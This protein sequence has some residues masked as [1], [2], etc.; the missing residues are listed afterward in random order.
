M[1]RVWADVVANAKI[2]YRSPAAVFWAFAFPILLMLVFGAIFGNEDATFTV[3]VQDN[4]DSEASRALVEA[5]EA[6]GSLEVESIDAG[7]D[8]ADVARDE[9]IHTTLVIPL[10]YGERLQR[11]ET[12]VLRVL[13]DPSRQQSLTTASIV[14]AVVEEVNDRITGG[15]EPVR[16]AESELAPGDG[17]GPSSYIG[18]FLPGVLGLTVMFNALV[19]SLEVHATLR[20]KGILRKIATTP[21]GRIE[22]VL[23]KALYQVILALV[24]AV[25]IVA[26]GMLFFDV[27]V[28]FT[29]EAV[30]MIVITAIL[31]AGIAMMMSRWVT[32]PDHANAAGSAVAMPMMFLAGTFFPLEAMPAFLRAIAGV[33]PLTYVNEALRAAMVTGDRGELL[34]HG[35][36]TAAMA[37]VAI[38]LGAAMIRWKEV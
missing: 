18:F 34:F 5:L 29:I 16:L 14:R 28:R 7:V 6:T 19:G 9:D 13:T 11:G 26:T 20:E 12:V 10:G 32:K 36:I 17:S 8:A 38:V 2:W 23:A 25:A 1:R 37:V 15:N 27:A 31:F 4:D 22:W 24:A 3:A 21:I 30:A 33:L 35:G